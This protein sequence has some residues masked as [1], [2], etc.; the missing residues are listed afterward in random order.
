ME[1][2]NRLMEKTV[3]PF[4]VDETMRRIEEIIKSQGGSVFAMFDHGR[5]ASEVGMKLP[6]NKVIVFGSPKVGTLLMQQDP[7]ISLELPLRISVWE[8]ADGKVS[9]WFPESGDD[10]LRIRDG[11]QRRHREDAR[12]R[13]E[14]RE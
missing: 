3:S 13:N 12:G 7:S 4:S 9:D 11:K 10:R 1:K 2:K 5:N 8:D 14:Y 6:P